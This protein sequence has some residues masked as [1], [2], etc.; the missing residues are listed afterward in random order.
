MSESLTTIYTSGAS[1]AAIDCSDDTP[2]VTRTTYLSGRSPPDSL[3][4][5]ATLW[6]MLA[7][8]SADSIASAHLFCRPPLPVRRGNVLDQEIRKPHSHSFLMTDSLGAESFPGGRKTLSIQHA[9]PDFHD[10]A[11]ND[12]AKPGQ[13][14]IRKPRTRFLPDFLSILFWLRRRRAVS[15][16]LRRSRLASPAPLETTSFKIQHS[17]FNIQHSPASAAPLTNAIARTRLTGLG[18]SNIQHSTSKDQH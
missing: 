13:S 5:K 1:L 15:A 10:S 4:T 12:S 9:A 14:Q 3:S 2:D 18:T 7:S 16:A 17:A 11:L 6:R 8:C